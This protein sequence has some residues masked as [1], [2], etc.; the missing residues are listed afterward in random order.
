MQKGGKMASNMGSIFVDITANLSGLQKNL[1]TAQGKLGIDQF[2]MQADAARF[3]S[4][5][6]AATQAADLANA[7]IK[8]QMAMAYL[9]ITSDDF[10]G[11]VGYTS[12]LNK[13]F[14]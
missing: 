8:N 9:G 3:A 7:D 14:K 6:E 13:L 5:G 2:N 11:N 1:Q 4:A 12:Y 10:G